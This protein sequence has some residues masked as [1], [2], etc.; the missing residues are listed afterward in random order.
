MHITD[1]LNTKKWGVFHHYLFNIQNNPVF[2]NNQNAGQTD[3]QTCTGEL[4]VQRIAKTLHEIGAGYYFITVMQGRKYMIAENAVYRS[5]IGDEN[6]DE[7]L[8]R[9][10]LIE[11]LYQELSKYDIDLYLYF[12]GDGP[13]KDEE[14]GSLFGFTEPR[15]NISMDFV[16]K[17][18]GV[19]RDYSVRYGNKIKG[20]WLDGMYQQQFGYSQELLEPYYR[21]VKEGNPEGIVAFNDGVKPYL[22]KHYAQEEFT[23][24]EQV[25]LSVIPDG[26]FQNEAQ[27][28]ILLPIGAEDRNIGATWAGGG[29]QCKKEELYAYA[30]KVIS[31]GGVVTFDCKLNRDGS[32][33][34]EQVEALR[35]VGSRL[36]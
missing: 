26:R 31:A 32:F 25:D 17:W 20:W 24:G 22:Y 5:I 33:D 6:A 27:T 10:D 13:Y 30:E 29:L 18:S 9:R 21:A 36:K 4:N 1:R 35:Y 23:S 28:H 16:Q 7:C 19:L 12:T 34:E 14:I 2:S 8:S 11:E 3:W 15:Q